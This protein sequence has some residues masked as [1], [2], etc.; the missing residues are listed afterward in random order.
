MA[1]RW[2]AGTVLST[3]CHLSASSYSGSRAPSLTVASGQGTVFSLAQEQ[4]FSVF[5]EMERLKFFLKPFSIHILQLNSLGHRWREGPQ[6]SVSLQNAL[7]IL[8]IYENARLYLRS[9]LTS[10]KL[11]VL[12]WNLE[13]KEMYDLAFTPSHTA[14][15]WYPKCPNIPMSWNLRVNYPDTATWVLYKHIYK[16][17]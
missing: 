17:S 10:P 1:C 2:H 6:H 12:Y 3:P 13:L 15:L 14:Q 16:L 11:I 9:L 5:F 8:K 4:A 7:R